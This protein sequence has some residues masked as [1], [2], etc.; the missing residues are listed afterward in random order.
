MSRRCSHASCAGRRRIRC[1]RTGTVGKIPR[2]LDDVE[3]C[4]A[5][6]R[7]VFGGRPIARVF[8][9]TRGADERAP[10]Q[11]VDARLQVREVRH[12]DQQFS[13]RDQ[14]APEL[15]ES[16]GLVR[17]WQMLQHVETQ[18]AIECRIAVWQR[19]D[20]SATDGRGRVV[21]IH[22]FDREAVRIR[23]NEHALAATGVEHARAGR[24]R[25]EV[26]PDAR[27]FRE[28]GRVVVP[29]WVGIAMVVAPDGVLAVPNITRGSGGHRARNYPPKDGVGV[30][31]TPN[32]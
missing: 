21:V 28:I 20:R 23:V 16:L 1:V 12:R 15:C 27:H 11:E 18:C 26:G 32:S 19:G 3:A 22:A 14:N 31:R 10:Q 29:V 5:G 13:A 17:V 9:L 30:I 8:G 7:E 2:V 6:E 4:P 24:E 25:V